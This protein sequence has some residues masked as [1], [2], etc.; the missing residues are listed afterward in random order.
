MSNYKTII[1]ALLGIFVITFISY[2][3]NIILFW[4]FVISGILFIMGVI[5]FILL[6]EKMKT[7]NTYKNN[8]IYTP[9]FASNVDYGGDK[10]LNYEIV[11]LG[12]NPAR[13]AFFYDNILGQNWS[14]GTQGLD[15]D[16][17]ILKHFHSY[18]KEDGIVL[19]PIVAF[20]SVSGYLKPEN[21]QLNY[22]AKFV[23]ILNHNQANAIPRGIEA[24]RWINYPLFYNWKYIYWLFNDSE[25]DNRLAIPEQIMQPVELIMDA[26]RWMECWKK[27]FNITDL[28]APL[29]KELQE[30]RK[31]SIRD[32][33]NLIDFCLE[34]SLKPVLIFPPVSKY[35]SRLFSEN[36]RE[37]YIYS[38]I[39]EANVKNIP[40]LDYLDDERWGDEGLYFNSFFLNLKGRKLFTQQ[41]LKDL[42]LNNVYE[43]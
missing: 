30:G 26:A 37:K 17:E 28:N 27:E 36:V 40:F 8:F 41:V 19:L 20:S 24:R 4:C 10:Q 38:F 18:I 43:N 14:T 31:K 15:K 29:S 5:A 2:F 32:L 13:F 3:F 39:R 1:L 35:L 22:V 16:F 42:N 21:D 25:K 12:S 7:T 33:Q 34:R 23:S 6:N 11:N 9:Q